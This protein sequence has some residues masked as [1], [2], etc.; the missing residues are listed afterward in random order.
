MGVY[1]FIS[2]WN[3]FAPANMLTR[4]MNSRTLPLVLNE[5]SPYFK[6]DWGDTMA[7]AAIITM[8]IILIFMLVQRQFV[9]GLA[10]GAVKS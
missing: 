3:E 1:A 5:F 10:I 4:S 6:V 7:A 2:S 9:A 8:P